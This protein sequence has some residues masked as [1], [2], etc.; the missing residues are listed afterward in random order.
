MSAEH[1]HTRSPL[2]GVCTWDLET[3]FLWTQIMQNQHGMK[4][5]RSWL[6]AES[7]KAREERSFSKKKRW[8]LTLIQMKN[9][10]IKDFILLINQQEPQ[11]HVRAGSKGGKATRSKGTELQIKAKPISGDVGVGQFQ[12]CLEQKRSPTQ[13]QDHKQVESRPSGGAHESQRQVFQRI[14]TLSYKTTQKRERTNTCFPISLLCT[15]LFLKNTM[16]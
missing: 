12:L 2:S 11:T 10:H 1:M 7:V 5:P 16:K 15:P 6:C 14:T 3:L 8:S 13:L 4:P 9:E